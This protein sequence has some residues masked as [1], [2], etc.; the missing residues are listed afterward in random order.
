[1]RQFLFDA[2][3]GLAFCIAWVTL[4]LSYFDVLTF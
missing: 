4:L 1:M 3:G 2:L